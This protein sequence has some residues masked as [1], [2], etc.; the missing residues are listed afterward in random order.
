[1]FLPLLLF[2]V[3]TFATVSAGVVGY[4]FFI[5]RRAL[6]ERGHDDKEVQVA[7]VEP[8]ELLKSDALSTISMWHRL[9]TRF[10][11]FERM[12][13]RLAESGL[14]WSVGRLTALMLLTG[15]V[16]FA[17]LIH[18]SWMTGWA[19]VGLSFGASTAS[20]L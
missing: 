15:A 12:R 6:V 1:M 2:F 18:R 5:E 19:S 14:N 17:L 11:C 20:V 8:A 13:Q 9:L 7:W 3:A 10:D 16:T 4:R